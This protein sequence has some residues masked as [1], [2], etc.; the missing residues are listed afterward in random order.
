MN[1]PEKVMFTLMLTKGT[2]S[3]NF[4]WEDQFLEYR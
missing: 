4:P 2:D 3:T 1:A